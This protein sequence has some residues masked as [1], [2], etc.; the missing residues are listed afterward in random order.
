MLT[1]KTIKKGADYAKNHL[2]CND[3]YSEKERAVGQWMGRGAGL[4]DL[5]GEVR[6]EQIEAIR[7]RCD[8]RNGQG[9]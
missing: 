2:S 7:N 3:Y 4:L 9:D 6:M 5:S 8:G 1:T